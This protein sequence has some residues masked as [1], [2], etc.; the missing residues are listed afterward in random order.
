MSKSPTSTKAP[1]FVKAEP[2]SE[3]QLSRITAKLRAARDLKLEIA[4]TE[5]ALKDKKSHLTAIE[6]VEL[7]EMF[8][9]AGINSLGLDPEGN[10]PGYD[11]SKEP[12]YRANIAASWPEEKRQA[13]FDWLKKNGGPDLI[14]TEIS[15]MLPQKSQAIVKQ[16][17]KALK[18]LKVTSFTVSESVPWSSLTAFVRECYKRQKKVPL[19]VLGADVGEVVNLKQRQTDSNKG[20]A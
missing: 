12:Y 10:M 13:A 15:I 18:A 6:R 16:V 1:A 4:Q 3:D 19:D 20:K 2:L 17:V 11:C 7:P 5:E 14:K 9:K 8:Q